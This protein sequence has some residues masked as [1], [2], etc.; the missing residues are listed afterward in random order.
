[1]R[2]PADDIILREL[3][4]LLLPRLCTLQCAA[5]RVKKEPVMGPRFCANPLG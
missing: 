2:L 3:A 4:Q 1:M 5:L